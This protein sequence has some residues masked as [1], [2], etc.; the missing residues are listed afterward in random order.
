L[1]GANLKGQRVLLCDDVISAGTAVREA[2][3]IIK[4]YG[5][6]LVGILVALDREEI[7]SAGSEKVSAVASVALEFKVQVISI[8]SLTDLLKYLE[9]DEDSVDHAASVR[10][11][12][13]KYGA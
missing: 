8:V 13:D 6:T 3:Q 12:R 9:D 4:D 5:G 10:D 7:S 1:V 11:Y 2:A